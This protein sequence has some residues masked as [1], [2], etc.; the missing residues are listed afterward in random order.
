MAVP[1]EVIR[2]AFALSHA[3]GAALLSLLGDFKVWRGDLAEMRGDSPRTETIESGHPA[4][5][6]G[7]ALADVL[8]MS[9]AIEL[10]DADCRTALSGA[11][12]IAEASPSAVASRKTMD[13]AERQRVSACKR[14]LV[15]LYAKLHATTG[16]VVPEWVAEREHAAIASHGRRRR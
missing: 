13:T 16:S 12:G 6:N 15:E 5:S 2:Q 8:L 7:S 14:R 4:V 9:R 10:L 3:R 1:E 11:Y